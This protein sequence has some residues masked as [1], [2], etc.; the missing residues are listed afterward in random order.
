MT[1]KSARVEET[2]TPLQ[3][4]KGSL[5]DKGSRRLWE[6]GAGMDGAQGALTRPKRSGVAGLPSPPPRY[7]GDHLGVVIT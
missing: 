7:V 2:A 4:T 5:G 3:L 6:P 1:G